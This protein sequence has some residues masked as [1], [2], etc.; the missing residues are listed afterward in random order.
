MIRIGMRRSL[1][2]TAAAV[3][4]AVP[5]MTLATAQS[6]AAIP[7]GYYEAG[8][9]A[10]YNHCWTPRESYQYTRIRVIPTSGASYLRCVAPGKIRLGSSSRIY[11]AY[12]LPKDASC[13][14]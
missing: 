9:S 12:S 3:A 10:N 13:M 8:T 11:F 1:I 2:A 5:C 7:C 6:A 4:I 14:T